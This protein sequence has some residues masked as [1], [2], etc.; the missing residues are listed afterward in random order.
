MASSLLE[1]NLAECL[2]PTKVP[3]ENGTYIAVIES[4]PAVPVGVPRVRQEASLHVIRGR[5]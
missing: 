4:S 5:Y 1:K 3:L 2:L